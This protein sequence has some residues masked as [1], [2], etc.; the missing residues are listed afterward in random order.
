MQ[1]KELLL[2]VIKVFAKGAIMDAVLKKYKNFVKHY[3]ELEFSNKEEDIHE[4]RILLRK[5]LT[6][7]TLYKNEE[8]KVIKKAFSKM[9]KLRDIQVEIL[10]LEK[11]KNQYNIEEYLQYLKVSEEKLKAKKTKKLKLPKLK[12]KGKKIN[13]DKKIK[14]Q[15]KKLIKKEFKDLHELRKFFKS[16]RYMVELKHSINPLNEKQIETLKKYQDILGE[17]QD[18]E[19]LIR[20]I[21]EFY[22]KKNSVNEFLEKC[23]KNEIDEFMNSE[24]EFKNLI[25]SFYTGKNK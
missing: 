14:K 1:Y 15:G 4:K 23:K 12:N 25:S 13:L 16:F 11:L 9:G 10:S 2:I 19:V 24:K 7:I 21:K 3:R 20:G 18:Y 22:H 17:I 8:T 6:I 5:I